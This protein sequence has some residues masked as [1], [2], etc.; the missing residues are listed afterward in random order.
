VPVMPGLD[1]LAFTTTATQGMEFVL[2]GG[3]DQALNQ[4]QFEGQY[5]YVLIDGPG[6]CSA[7]ESIMLATIAEHVLWVVRPG[8]SERFMVSK[9]I[10]Q[11]ARHLN[12]EWAGIVL[13]GTEIMVDKE[14]AHKIITVPTET[15]KMI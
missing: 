6:I 13:N 1:L 9:A 10:A 3:F 7:G 8:I 11:V 4:A 14:N 2:R 5:D 15:S 12:V